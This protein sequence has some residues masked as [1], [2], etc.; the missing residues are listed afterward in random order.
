MTIINGRED[1]FKE[2]SGTALTALAWILSDS[3]RAQRFLDLTGLTPEILRETVGSAATQRAVL[4]FL[5]AHEPDLIA[6]AESLGVEPAVLAG[7]RDR[8]G[9]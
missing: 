2:P 4:D 5:C 3:A 8:I 7:M 6:A 9:L 1:T